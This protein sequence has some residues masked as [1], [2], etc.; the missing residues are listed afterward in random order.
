M[1]GFNFYFFFALLF[2]SSL[3]NADL[4]AT[5]HFNRFT[6]CWVEFFLV[7]ISLMLHRYGKYSEATPLYISVHVV[8]NCKI[9]RAIFALFWLYY[10]P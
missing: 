7:L 6:I 2:V 4:Y 8:Y 5:F 3:I 9:Y 1:K 10:S